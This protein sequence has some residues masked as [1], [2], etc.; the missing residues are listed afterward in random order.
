MVKDQ[1]IKYSYA[2][3]TGEGAQIIE[4]LSHAYGIFPFRSR[5]G[6]V[7]LALG[8]SFLRA[9]ARKKTGRGPG[10]RARDQFF[11]GPGPIFG[12]SVSVVFS[13]PQLPAP[14]PFEALSHTMD[15]SF[16]KSPLCINGRVILTWL[17]LSPYAI[18]DELVAFRYRHMQ[19]QFH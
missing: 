12:I 11:P 9:M 3:P 5:A 13:H 17:A 8:T 10:K 14:Y 2:L 19:P 16:L 15:I 1:Q 18:N 6:L 4:G 7:F